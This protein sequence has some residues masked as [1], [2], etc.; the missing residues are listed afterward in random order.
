MRTSVE[1]DRFCF[2]PFVTAK[3]NYK[4][5]QSEVDLKG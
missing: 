4:M 3:G 2:V 1:T 5:A